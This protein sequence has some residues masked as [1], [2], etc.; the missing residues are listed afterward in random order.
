[1]SFA[2][3]EQI[4]ANAKPFEA[5]FTRRRMS[6]LIL[7]SLAAFLSACFLWS[8]SIKGFTSHADMIVNC[9]KN[10]NAEQVLQRM[11]HEE[12]T[13]EN[14]SRHILVA[15]EKAGIENDDVINRRFDSIIKAFRFNIYKNKNQPEYQLKAGFKGRGSKGEQVLVKSILHRIAQ[16]LDNSGGAIDNIGEI[17]DQYARIQNE[18]EKMSASRHAQLEDATAQLQHLDVD[19][20][21]VYEEVTAIRSLPDPVAQ[22]QEAPSTS[23]DPTALSMMKSL[24]Q[25]LE[26]LLDERDRMQAND[27]V[28]ID[29]MNAVDNDIRE[30]RGEIEDL[31][32][33]YP[34]MY[35]QTQRVP[36]MNVS[37]ARDGAIDQALRSIESLNTDS[38]REKISTVQQT[39]R[40]DAVAQR[41]QVATL[42]T[43]TND[44]IGESYSVRDISEVKN[45]PT[46]GIPSL[47]HLLMFGFGSL[48]LGSVVALNF[49]PE[50]VDRGFE[51]VD[52]A[53]QTLGLPVVG[54]LPAATNLLDTDGRTKTSIANRVVSFCEIALFAAFLVVIFLCF[55]SPSI[56]EAFFV[57]PLHGL[58][59]IAWMFMGR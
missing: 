28:T 59:Q 13:E 50:L 33:N 17:E 25:Q 12:L 29:H 30:V 53:E 4:I 34:E 37:H 31:E 39:I 3:I 36:T 19:L 18:I 52:E 55:I 6:A 42:R 32:D 9:S 24:A 1:M 46:E 26:D 21:V 57:N 51:S 56:R 16:K 41:E 49:R 2:K 45:R 48:A 22:T 10:A 23:I 38:V 5:K 27:T 11:V 7:T 40:T 43:L 54:K 35:T 58:A 47:A 44:S 20:S 15:S 8:L 14:L